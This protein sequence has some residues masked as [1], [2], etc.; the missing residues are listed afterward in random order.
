MPSSSSQPNATSSTVSSATNLLSQPKII[1]QPATIPSNLNQMQTTSSSSSSSNSKQRKTGSSSSQS[2]SSSKQQSS[3]Q[4]ALAA[5]SA[6]AAATNSSNNT[7]ANTSS[8]NNNTSSN[9]NSSSTNDNSN[10]D[11]DKSNRSV[12]KTVSSSSKSSSKESREK[13]QSSKSQK[14]HSAKDNSST[15]YDSGNH[16]QLDSN[17]TSSI[18]TNVNTLPNKEG[19]GQKFTTSNFTETVVVNSESVFGSE[20]KSTNQSSSGNSGGNATPLMK[21]RKLDA[22]KSSGSTIE[23]INRDIIKDVS[24]TLVPLPFDK[25]DSTDMKKVKE[26]V[27]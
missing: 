20:G 27:K 8:S 21:K 16:S 24:V 1:L 5:S 23:D 13:Y 17:T 9:S 7:N 11:K 3:N 2:S 15:D 26:L 18:I 22:G 6:A 14:G 25:V 4:S 10:K 19:L 12:N